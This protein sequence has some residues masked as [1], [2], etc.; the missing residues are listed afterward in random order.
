MDKNEIEK[1][2][3]QYQ[4][5]KANLDAY[6]ETEN[7]SYEETV[8]TVQQLAGLLLSMVKSRLLG[9]GALEDDT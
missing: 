1:A 9:L 4:A 6:C 5:I 7:P 3:R 2:V 8:K